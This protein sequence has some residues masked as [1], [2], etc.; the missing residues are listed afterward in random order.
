MSAGSGGLDADG[1]AQA[2]SE[3]RNLAAITGSGRRKLGLRFPDSPERPLDP[4]TFLLDEWLNV[5]QGEAARH[6]D[7]DTVSADQDSRMQSA[8]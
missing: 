3:V 4:W 6:D 1:Q 8:I 7:L 5:S 2:L